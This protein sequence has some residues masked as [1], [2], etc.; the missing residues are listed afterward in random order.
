MT[1]ADRILIAVVAV[2]AL[3]S[4]PLVSSAS[5][6]LAGRADVAVVQAPG[7]RTVIELSRDASYAVEGR[8]GVLH[9]DVAA[10]EIRVVSADCPDQVCVAS[11][12]ARPG[13]PIVCAPNGVSV[14]LSGSSEGEV[15]AVSR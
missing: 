15:D 5:N 14:S 4:M 11:G 7:G 12:V 3:M 6:A 1:R 2:V 8:Q 9:L 13:K 10:G